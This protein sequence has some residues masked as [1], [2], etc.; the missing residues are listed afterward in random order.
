MEHLNH[1]ALERMEITEPP[2]SFENLEGLAT[3]GFEGVRK[4]V[5]EA[6]TQLK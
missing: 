5:G 6:D 2:F 3:L 1:I 4:L